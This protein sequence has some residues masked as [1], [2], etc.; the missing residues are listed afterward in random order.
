MLH[1]LQDIIDQC[2]MHY[3]SNSYRG[4]TQTTPRIHTHERQTLTLT[5]WAFVLTSCKSYKYMSIVCVQTLISAS[6]DTTV[7]VDWELK[8]KDYLPILVS[9]FSNVASSSTPV[10]WGNKHQHFSLD[11]IRFRL[12]SYLFWFLIS[13]MLHLDLYQSA[14]LINISIFRWIALDLDLNGNT[15]E[16]PFPRASFVSL[17]WF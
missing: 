16:K 12:R 8:K 6:L 3:F 10:I 13:P 2:F 14:E 5:H 9:D 15:D 17:T 7:T 4:I 1:M 11:S